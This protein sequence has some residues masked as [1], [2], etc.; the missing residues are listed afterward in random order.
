M[1]EERE[2]ENNQ[3]S[4]QPA[5]LSVDNVVEIDGKKEK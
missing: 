3:A 5:C 1:H 2:Q 4:N